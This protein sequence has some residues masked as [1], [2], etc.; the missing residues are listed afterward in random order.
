MRQWI[1]GLRQDHLLGALRHF[2]PNPSLA[3]SF[4]EQGYQRLLRQNNANYIRCRGKYHIALKYDVM[5]YATGLPRD[6]LIV[7]RAS[8]RYFRIY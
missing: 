7:G 1:D 5:R 2:A 6:D 4:P 8:R 3:C